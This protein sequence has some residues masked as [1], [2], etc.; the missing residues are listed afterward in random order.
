MTHST[1]SPVTPLRQRMI[2][3]MRLPGL[4]ARTQQVYIDGVRGLAAHY[5]RSPDRLTEE[6]VRFYLL[7]LRDRGA[8]RGTFKTSHYGIRRPGG[9]RSGP[10]AVAAAQRP[11]ERIRNS[12]RTTHRE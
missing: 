12:P 7:D 4:S 3:D 8:A 11:P 9:G 1:Q 6:E 5:K 10:S 2:E